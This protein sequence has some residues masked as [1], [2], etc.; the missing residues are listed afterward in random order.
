MRRQQPGGLGAA[1]PVSAG[2]AGRAGPARSLG[3]GARFGGCPGRELRCLRPRGCGGREPAHRGPRGWRRCG[4]ASE[5]PRRPPRQSCCSG[6]GRAGPPLTLPSTSLIF[7]DFPIRE[8]FL[9]LRV[10]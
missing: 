8:G 3:G 7:L 10:G 1:G 2:L 6:P 5:G 9:T 4:R